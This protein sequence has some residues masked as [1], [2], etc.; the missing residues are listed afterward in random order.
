MQILRKKQALGQIFQIASFQK[1]R[2]DFYI[3]KKSVTRHYLAVTQI[4]H[5]AGYYC[6]RFCRPLDTKSQYEK[7]DAKP[8]QNSEDFL[9]H[10]LIFF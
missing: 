4:M 6:I 5:L 3:R 1:L 7:Y 8:S 9:Q 2:S 10:L